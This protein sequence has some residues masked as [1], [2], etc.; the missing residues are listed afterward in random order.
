[1]IIC[2]NVFVLSFFRS[3]SSITVS[4]SY[5]AWVELDCT[6]LLC[7]IIF[8]FNFD[9]YPPGLFSKLKT[10]T[11]LGVKSHVT[12]ISGSCL[13]FVWTAL[14]L[15][16]Q[17][18]WWFDIFS[19][20]KHPSYAAAADRFKPDT[21]NKMNIWLPSANGRVLSEN[22]CVIVLELFCSC[23]KYQRPYI[24]ELL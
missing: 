22:S 4:F 11:C 14:P 2:I 13:L 17:I 24:T 5:L 16:A 19:S 9:M 6:Y 7:F 15:Q 8:F 21:M 1:M 20:L 10:M 3:I 18:V 12:V 23:L